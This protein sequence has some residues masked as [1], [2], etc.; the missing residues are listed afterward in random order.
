MS[1]LDQLIG[2]ALAGQRASLARLLSIAE[3]A[4]PQLVDIEQQISAL[5]GNAYVIGITGP[6]GAGKSTLINGLLPHVTS[7]FDK[8]AVLAV[9]PSSPFSNGAILGDRVRMHGNLGE[10]VYIRSLASRGETGGMARAASTCVRIFDAC[11]WPVIIIET[12]GI[13][14]VELDIMNLAD[15]VL[16]VLNPGWGDTIQANKAGLTEA[17]DVFTINKADKPGVEQTRA[18]LVESLNMLARKPSPTVTETIAT[19]GAGL[20]T[21]WQTLLEHREQMLNSGELL[22]RRA[23]RKSTVM[24]KLIED[25]IERRL[26]ISLSSAVAS[27]LL[28]GYSPGEVDLPAVVEKLLDSMR[29]N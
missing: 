9:D 21:L 11:G 1:D 18:D 7:H 3:R 22:A 15:S 27:E 24:R 20:D 4:D 12:L 17:G 6:P 5:T 2:S 28:D 19:T 13:G 29:N 14:Q 23:A 25:E 16:V 8:A 26:S 10:S